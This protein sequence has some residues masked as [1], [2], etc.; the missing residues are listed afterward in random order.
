MIIW[1]FVGKSSAVGSLAEFHVE[2]DEVWVVMQVV[3]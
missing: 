1:S 3:E 2:L